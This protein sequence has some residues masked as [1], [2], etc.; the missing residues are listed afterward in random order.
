MKI[1]LKLLFVGSSF[2]PT[3]ITGKIVKDSIQQNKSNYKFHE[4]KDKVQN[5]ISFAYPDSYS[6][7]YDEFEYKDNSN[8]VKKSFNEFYSIK[9]LRM[10]Q[11][12]KYFENSKLT[13][14]FDSSLRRWTSTSIGQI[15]AANNNFITE[16]EFQVT[17]NERQK[18]IEFN[19]VY[20][21]Q[22][23][24]ADSFI[25]VDIT[26]RIERVKQ[27]GEWGLNFNGIIQQEII[28]DPINSWKEH[29]QYT[30]AILSKNQ[31]LNLSNIEIAFQT[32]EKELEKSDL[33]LP[34]LKLDSDINGPNIKSI[35]ERALRNDKEFLNEIGLNSTKKYKFVDINAQGIYASFKN[36]DVVK[37]TLRDNQNEYTFLT[38]LTMPKLNT[39]KFLNFDRTTNDIDHFSQQVYEIAKKLFDIKD[40][41]FKFV[42]NSTVN[43]EG[44]KQFNAKYATSLLE[45][46]YTSNDGIKNSIQVV[47]NNVFRLEDKG[48]RK[49]W[50]DVDYK[51][52]P[53][54]KDD[55]KFEYTDFD[56]KYY[57]PIKPTSI[58]LSDK[59]IVIMKGD[60]KIIYF[61][62]YKYFLNLY[63][64]TPPEVKLTRIA[65]DKIML[66]ALEVWKGEIEIDAINANEI[67]KLEIE[68]VSDTIKD[69]EITNNIELEKGITKEI[70]FDFI[71]PKDNLAVINTNKNLEVELIGNKL[72]IKSN[73][74][75]EQKF[76][77]FSNLTK[78]QLEITV[79]TLLKVIE[80]IFENNFE[81][82]ETNKVNTFQFKNKAQINFSKLEIQ[83]DE[84]DIDLVNETFNFYNSKPGSYIVKFKYFNYEFSH[85]II[86][87]NNLN[88]KET[89]IYLDEQNQFEYLL[90]D[91]KI[92]HQS[93]LIEFN[94]VENK[95]MGTV[96]QL[97]QT[98]ILYK[99]G[100]FNTLKFSNEQN[101]LSPET[102]KTKDNKLSWLI[103]I[104]LIPTVLS[105][106]G[107]IFVYLKR[108]K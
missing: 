77:L 51:F 60:K 96:N 62:N 38:R 92:Y 32:K 19:N 100:T 107:F 64:Q 39:I 75:E 44:I 34:I 23:N 49:T 21:Y 30:G 1:L 8:Y 47:C 104:V 45:F 35:I 99:E 101:P 91:Q 7:N 57:E 69:F 72:L 102:Q 78:K 88:Y 85:E 4:Y 76:K 80:P 55:I 67:F 70:K 66:E 58:S 27:N 11:Y 33:Q 108:K 73:S 10:E 81:V 12:E 13:F 18:F 94:I 40:G 28:I 41:S 65:E 42:K 61:K 36:N 20:S 103:P 46:L 89:T 56:D 24:N 53:N 48:K 95:I 22:N 26:M 87:T 3:F 9:K 79:N 37:L 63:F 14:N 5:N 97:E 29:Y 54:F 105:I 50:D 59:N 74:L 98:I 82:F 106:C 84:L 83:S 6:R 52:L 71:D 31:G 17:L 90:E 68:V 2:S 86:L 16:N 25:Q 15:E 93:S 43:I